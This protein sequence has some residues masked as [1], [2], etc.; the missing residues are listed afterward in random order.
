M[1]ITAGYILEIPE[2]ESRSGQAI[3]P[4]AFEWM[5]QGS[6]LLVVVDPVPEKIG[7][8]HLSEEQQDM[9]QMGTGYIIAVGPMAGLMPNNQIGQ[10]ECQAPE[11]LLGKH[12]MFGFH[13]GKA[14]RFSVFD[15]DYDSKLLL[16]SPLD[17]WMIDINP[18]PYTFD[19]EFQQAYV[20]TE[21]GKEDAARAK[22]DVDRQ[23]M[24]RQREL[25]GDDS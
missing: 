11:D 1:A 25:G 21:Q 10:V 22:L 12:I 5:P 8:I 2:A 15:S 19:R 16:L 4:R 18:D 14:V 24:I 20:L 17:I 13:A 23:L 7:M 6:R 9:Q 3:V